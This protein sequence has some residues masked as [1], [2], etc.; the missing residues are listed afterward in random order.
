MKAHRSIVGQV[1]NLRPIGN[2]PVAERNVFSTSFVGLSTVQPAFSRLLE[3]LHF[4]AIFHAHTVCGAGA[5]AC[6]LVMF[7]RRR[8][9]FGR[10]MRKTFLSAPRLG[11][12]AQSCSCTAAAQ[13]LPSGRSAPAWQRIHAPGIGRARGWQ[14]K[15]PAPQLARTLSKCRNSSSR[16]LASSSRKPNH[17]TAPCP[18]R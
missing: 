4:P 7:Y 1:G 9:R 17:S 13:D 10:R 11:D 2:R 3:F 16:L 8:R 5:F 18:A 6:Q 15:A 12:H 14:A